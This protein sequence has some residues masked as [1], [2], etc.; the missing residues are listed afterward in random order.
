MPRVSGLL[1]PSAFAIGPL[2]FIALNA[3][4]LTCLFFGAFTSL[5]MLYSAFFKQVC[6]LDEANIAFVSAIVFG[7]LA[8]NVLSLVSWSNMEMVVLECTGVTLVVHYSVEYVQRRWKSSIWILG[9]A[10]LGGWLV[11]ALA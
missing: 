1:L 9:P 10:M 8:A 11:P 3:T 4:S 2:R 5:F 6:C 7:P